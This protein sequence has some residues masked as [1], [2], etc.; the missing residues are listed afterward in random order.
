MATT[1]TGTASSAGIWGTGTPIVVRSISVFNN[2]TA[3]VAGTVSIRDGDNV[4]NR[5]Q[6]RIASATANDRVFNEFPGTGV[7]C[8]GLSIDIGAATNI[9]WWVSYDNP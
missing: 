1:A 9:V 2:G 6:V 4:A 3:G 7:H 5:W 8:N